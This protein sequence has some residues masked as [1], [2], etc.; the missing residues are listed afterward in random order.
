MLVLNS[1]YSYPGGFITYNWNP[2]FTTD[3]KPTSDSSYTLTATAY[4]YNYIDFSNTSMWTP[5]NSG[6]TLIGYTKSTGEIYYL[7]VGTG[8]T[9]I[10]SSGVYNVRIRTGTGT[11]TKYI[12][13]TCNPDQTFVF[14]IKQYDDVARTNLIKTFYETIRVDE[15]YNA[16]Q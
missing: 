4:P 8:A 5:L 11:S 7:P 15:N 9:Q 6:S 12:T 10:S 1:D 14:E 2:G 16:G 3:V 13:G